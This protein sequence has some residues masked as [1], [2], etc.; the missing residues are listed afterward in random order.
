M[1][2]EEYSAARRALSRH[3]WH[4]HEKSFGSGTLEDRL[5]QH[6]EMHVISKRILGIGPSHTHEKLEENETAIEEANRVL[7]EGED[8]HGQSHST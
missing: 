5:E 7:Q 3:M 4:H 8:Q 1:P 6:G 2:S